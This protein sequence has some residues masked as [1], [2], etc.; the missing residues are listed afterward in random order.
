MIDYK[1][2]KHVEI[3]LS[4]HCNAACPLCPRN[5]FGHPYPYDL[6]YVE[7]HLT[8]KEIKKIFNKEFLDELTYITFEG[9]FGDPLMN[10]ELLQI[11]DY[12]NKPIIIYTNGSLQKKEFWQN[13]AKRPVKVVFGIDGLSGIHEIYRRGTNFIKIIKNAKTFI[14]SGGHAVWKMIRFEH[15]QH[16]I[17][18]CKNLSVELGFRDFLIIDHGRNIGPVFDRD[19]KLENV[20]GNFDGPKELKFYKDLVTDGDILIEDI[21]DKPKQSIKCSAVHNSSIYITSTGEVYPCCFM[22]FSPRTY[23]KGRWHQPVNKQIKQMLQENNAIMKPLQ[24]CIE[25]FNN[26]PEKWNIKNYED[27]RLIVCDSY[28]GK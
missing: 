26:I 12:L 28:C 25:W 19:G 10:P 11:I 3:E 14:Q 5:L 24:E 17:E 22:G 15:N 27:G 2:I 23:G 18:E 21:N 9:N 20:L 13:L 8:L 1:S 4:S 6:F 16:Q 7:K